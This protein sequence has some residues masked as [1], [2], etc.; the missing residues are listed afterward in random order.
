MSVKQKRLLQPGERIG[1]LVVDDSAVTR[2]LVTR[3]LEQTPSVYVAG[4]APNGLIA[5]QRL[6]EL[7]PDVMILDVEMPEMGGLETLRRAKKLHPQL[8]VV[9]FS[10]Y[11]ERGG[12]T[13]LE[14]LGL[15][16]DDYITKAASGALDQS[17][18]QLPADW[19]QGQLVPRVLQFFELPGG[20]PSA[21]VGGSPSAAAGV[22]S[23]AAVKAAPKLASKVASGP[24]QQPH[25]TSYKSIPLRPKVVV[26]GVSTGGPNA[27]TAIL[28][29][30]PA[31]FPIPILLVQHMS[32]LFTRL[33]AERLDSQCRLRVV[34]AVHGQTVK[35]GTIHIAPGDFHMV[36]AEADGEV[37][38]CLN[39]SPPQNSCRPSVDAL[40]ASVADVYGGAVLAL[41]LTGMGCD[42]LRGT[43]ML[44]N[45]G[46]TVLAQ[47]QATSIVWGMPGVVVNAGLADQV[48]ALHE[49]VPA[50]LRATQ[51]D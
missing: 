10:A 16:A 17:S 27:L 30:F 24:A 28:P 47:D 18:Q 48:L 51:Q 22:S 20:L 11:T 39:Q 13:T 37:R 43:R 26:I 46:A 32:A 25:F 19:L 9:M 44:K 3:A 34:E 4:S 21:A 50:V 2:N 8:R 14:A 41:V 35:A 42:G 7:R 23:S 40:F 12:E 33:L 49:V 5:L 6:A 15:G 36:V 1:V 31:D 38:I 29:L 45:L